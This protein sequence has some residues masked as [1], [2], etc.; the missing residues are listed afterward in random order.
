MNYYWKQIHYYN[1]RKEG[2]FQYRLIGPNFSK[3][4]QSYEE[5]YNFCVKNKIDAKCA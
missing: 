2:I 3:D 5:L 1:N 4:F